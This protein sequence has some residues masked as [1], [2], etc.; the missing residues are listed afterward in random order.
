MTFDIL[1]WEPG[2]L[3]KAWNLRRGELNQQCSAF[4]ATLT[5]ESWIGGSSR[6]AQRLSGLGLGYKH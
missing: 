3:P 6:V 1:S 4:L 2:S 5:E